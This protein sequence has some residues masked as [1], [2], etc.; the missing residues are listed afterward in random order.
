MP[1][2]VRASSSAFTSK[3][4]RILL[5]DDEPAVTIGLQRHL[6]TEFDISIAQGGEQAIALVDTSNPFAVIVTDMRMPGMDGVGVL[7]AMREKAPDTVRILLTGYAD[8]DSAISAVNDG[9]VF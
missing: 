5:I 2:T 3:G 6:R 8:V 9:N 4:P 7:R 1:P